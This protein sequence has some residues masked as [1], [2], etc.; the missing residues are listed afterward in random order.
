MSAL[1]WNVAFMYEMDCVGAFDAIANALGKAL[2]FVS[3]C[4]RQP[5]IGD[6]GG[7]VGS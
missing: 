6:A 4:S 3:S 1:F 7:V 2:E 5:D